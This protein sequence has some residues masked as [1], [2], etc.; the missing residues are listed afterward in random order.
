M[1]WGGGG[2]GRIGWGSLTVFNK[3]QLNDQH[4][5]IFQVVFV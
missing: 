3:L 5:I 2:G 4:E 1:E